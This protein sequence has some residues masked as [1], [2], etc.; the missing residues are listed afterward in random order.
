MSPEPAGITLILDDEGGRLKNV[1][2]LLSGSGK[3]KVLYAGNLEEARS[4]LNAQSPAVV[5][6]SCSSGLSEAEARLADLGVKPGWI[7]AGAT[8]EQA[9]DP[10]FLRAAMQARFNDILTVPAE[11]D[12]LLGALENGMRH[13][14]GPAGAKGKV[15]VLYSSKGG[16]GV[17]TLAVNLALALNHSGGVRIG[18]L[19]LDLQCGVV[20]S[21]LNLQPTQT[22]GKLGD[23]P[24]DDSNTLRD[25]LLSRITNHE[26][27][28]RVIAAPPVLHDGLN[29]SAEMVTQILR[30]L[31][32]RFDILVVDTPKWVGDRLVAALDEADLILLIAE[33]QIPALAKVRESL[34]LFSRFEYPLDKVALLFNRVEKAS[35]LQP[36]EAAEALSRKV[37]FALPAE[38]ARLLDAANRGVPPLSEA[39]AKGP[40]AKS[41][42]EFAEKLRAD[43]GFGVPKAVKKKR[44]FLFGRRAS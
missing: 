43:L 36:E 22:L 34:R 44:G 30:I 1:P 40:F 38:A 7:I 41:M 33:P 27:G 26:S 9:S 19:D 23:V 13:V 15:V 2:D 28:I 42:V 21:L 16:S 6:V 17:T 11:A 14:Q 35:E 12:S 3:S 32:D 31:R 29:I 18:L 8:A 24:V 10:E 25:E 20:A 37:Y 39:Q 4:G 5:L